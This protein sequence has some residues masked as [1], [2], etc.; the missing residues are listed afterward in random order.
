MRD[1]QYGSGFCGAPAAPAPHEPGLLMEQPEETIG[2]GVRK[3]R[4][5][6]RLVDHGDALSTATVEPTGAGRGKAQPLGA[7]QF[8]VEVVCD[9]EIGEAVVGQR[10]GHPE[11]CV[12]GGDEDSVRIRGVEGPGVGIKL[13]RLAGRSP[14]HEVVVDRPRRAADPDPAEGGGLPD[15]RV[16]IGLRPN[17]EIQRVLEQRGVT[18]GDGNKPVAE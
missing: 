3:G 7:V 17:I 4:I 14:R 9:V 15:V 13:V 8:L 5:Q 16:I 18:G 10:P 6:S 1:L 11:F 12:R 2:G